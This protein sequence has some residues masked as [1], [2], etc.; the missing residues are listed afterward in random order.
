MAVV[1]LDER[2]LPTVVMA[3]DGG[4]QRKVEMIGEIWRVDDE[5][6]RTPINRRYVEVILEGGKHVMLFEDLV[7]NVWF[8]QMP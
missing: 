7:T 8:V 2:G 3:E 5:W 1:E 4:E 6:W